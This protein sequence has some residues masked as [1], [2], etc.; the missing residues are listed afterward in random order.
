MKKSGT[1]LLKG[2]FGKLNIK[3]P[4]FFGVTHSRKFPIMDCGNSDDYAI[5]TK[6]SSGQCLY[7]PKK[8]PLMFDYLPGVQEIPCSSLKLCDDAKSKCVNGEDFPY[9]FK[10]LFKLNGGLENCPDVLLE[11]YTKPREY[12]VGWNHH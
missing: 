9:I 3:L 5:I 4:N 1:G 10:A 2:L 6:D 12:F 8:L 11:T 7:I